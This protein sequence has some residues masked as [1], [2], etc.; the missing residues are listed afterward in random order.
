MVRKTGTPEQIITK[1]NGGRPTAI[2][3]HSIFRLPDLDQ[4]YDISR[5]TIS[6]L[7][8]VSESYIGT[9]SYPG[10]YFHP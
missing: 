4:N 1:P 7:T 3:G 10:G 6:C 2:L 5:L 8:G 9:G